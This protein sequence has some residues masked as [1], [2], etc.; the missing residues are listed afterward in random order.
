MAREA[1]QAPG[2]PPDACPRDP[3]SA[4]LPGGPHRPA[5]HRKHRQSTYLDETKPLV[6]SDLVKSSRI[7]EYIIGQIPRKWGRGGAIQTAESKA[8]Y[9]ATTTLYMAMGV[10]A[11]GPV[12]EDRSVEQAVPSA[13]LRELATRTSRRP[14]FRIGSTESVRGQPEASG[15]SSD[16]GTA[17]SRRT[18]PAASGRCL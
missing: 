3:R 9:V 10:V 11:T 18:G 7:D 14:G 8:A 17:A 13:V 2:G 16:T 5:L 4:V 12:S 1:G 6:A 15:W